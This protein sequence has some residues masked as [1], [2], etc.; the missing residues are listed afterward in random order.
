MEGEQG[1]GYKLFYHGEDGRIKKTSSGQ[2][3]MK[4][5]IVYT[6]R[7]RQWR[8]WQTSMDMF[9]NRTQATRT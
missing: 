4:W 9:E 5:W 8:S 2:I 7:R 3:W 1:H 6:P